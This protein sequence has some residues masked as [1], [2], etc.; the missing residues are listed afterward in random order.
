MFEADYFWIIMTVFIVAAIVVQ[1][2]LDRR[3]SGHRK[4]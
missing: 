1:I 4:K 3:Q 2:I